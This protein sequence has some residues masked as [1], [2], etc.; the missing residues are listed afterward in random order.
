MTTLLI[1]SLSVLTADLVHQANFIQNPSLEYDRDRDTFPDGW[2]PFAFDSP[3]RLA[4]DDAV[5]RT[6]KRSLSI[7]DSHRPGTQRDWK[8]CTGRWVSSRR[9]VKRGTPYRLEVWVKTNGVT[10]HA[11]AHMAWQRGTKWISE[12]ATQ[13]ITGTKDWTNVTVIAIPPDT[14]DSVIVSLNL[15]RS[16]GTAWFDDVTI[17]GAS[18][19]MPKVTYVFKDTASW[20]PFA[21]PLDDTNRDTIDL[22]HLLDAPAGKHGFL[23]TRSDGHFYFSD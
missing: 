7:S 15:S 23:T 11:Y 4:W 2:R 21:F 13:R 20:F 17:S 5:A 6:G 3:A 8:Q 12:E 1:L 18:D 9:P 14:A 16:S 10:G 19:T 22:T